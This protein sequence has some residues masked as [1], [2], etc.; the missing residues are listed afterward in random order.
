MLKKAE[1]K[2]QSESDAAGV[3][4]ARRAALLTLGRYGSYTAPA[5]LSLTVVGDAKAGVRVSGYR[6]R[7]Y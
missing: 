5:I 2:K 1:R 4:K 6:P 7:R 3:D